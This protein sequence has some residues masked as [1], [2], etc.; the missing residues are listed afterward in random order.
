LGKRIDRTAQIVFRARANG[1]CWTGDE[2]HQR[3]AILCRR[4]RL[5]PDDGVI[6]LLAKCRGGDLPTQIAVDARIVDEEVAGDVPPLPPVLGSPWCLEG[7]SCDNRAERPLPSGPAVAHTI[8]CASA[9]RSLRS[10]QRPSLFQ[11][12]ASMPRSLTIGRHAS[13]TYGTTWRWTSLP[14]G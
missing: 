12:Q 13:P 4:G 14:I 11:R 7:Q 2:R 6:G 9:S 8:A 1:P 5:L 3:A 10:W